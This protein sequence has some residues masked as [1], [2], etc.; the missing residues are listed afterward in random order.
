M[1]LLCLLTTLTLKITYETY[2]NYFYV[3]KTY[4]TNIIL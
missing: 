2:T 3:N 4:N 1:S